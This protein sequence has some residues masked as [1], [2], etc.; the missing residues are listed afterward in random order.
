[1]QGNFIGSNAAGTAGIGNAFAGIACFNAAQNNVIGSSVLGAGNL[2]AFNAFSGIEVFDSTTTGNDFNANSIF[3]NGALGINLFGGSENGF[4]V[5][6]NDAQDPDSGPNQLQN[7]PVLTSANSAA[8]IQGSLNSVPSKPYRIDFFS[9][10]DRRRLRV[11]RGPDLDW[12]GQ[13]HDRRQRQRQLQHGL[14]RLARDR[15]GGH[16]DCDGYRHRRVRHVG[17][18]RRQNGRP[19]ARSA[20]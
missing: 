16:G 18:F 7:Y 12:R 19:L 13:R 14:P 3:S 20:L 4:G 9:S 17:I 8:V 11:R 1:M 10:P 15:L 5:T 6:A 2:I